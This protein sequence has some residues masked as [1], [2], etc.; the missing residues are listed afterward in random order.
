MKKKYD[1]VGLG[2]VIVDILVKVDDEFLEGLKLKKG[3]FH[4]HNEK[5]I[6]DIHS[7]I[8]G[9]QYIVMPG[10]SVSNTLSTIALLGGKTAFFGKIGDDEL[11]EIYEKAMIKDGIKLN[12]TKTKGLTGKA[13]TFITPDSERTFAVN[14]GVASDFRKE[15]ILEDEIKNSK[16]LHLEGYTLYNPKL[17]E[18]TIHAMQIAKKHR[19]KIS[20]DLSDQNMIKNNIQLTKEVIKDYVDFLFVNEYEAQALTGKP[21]EEA[22]NEFK[23]EIAVVKLGEKGSL[24]KKGSEIYRIEPVKANAVDTTGA[25]DSYAGG[26]LFGL[27]KGYDIE[28]C[29]KIGSFISKLVVQQVGSR[30]NKALRKEIVNL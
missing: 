15:E 28:R 25:G 16:I 14:L 3:T 22:I 29:G 7:K 8:K 23:T 12:I 13:M 27:A 19:V 18:A 4:G 17:R 26:F 2:N 24:I 6:Q 20:I 1:I 5:Q 30:L 9:M 11:A 10:C 21:A